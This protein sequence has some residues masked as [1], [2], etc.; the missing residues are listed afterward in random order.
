MEGAA[1]VRLHDF[2]G[3]LMAHDPRISQIGL[4]ASK[5][6]II[7]PAHPDPSNANQDFAGSADRSGPFSKAEQTRCLAN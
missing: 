7:G 1:R 2:A 3:N 4:S 5:D 6:M